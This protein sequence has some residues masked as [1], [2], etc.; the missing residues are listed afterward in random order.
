MSLEELQV[1]LDRYDNKAST[2]D[3]ATLIVDAARRV[4]EASKTLKANLEIWFNRLGID[5][6][7]WWAKEIHAYLVTEYEGYQTTS[8]SDP[9]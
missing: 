1:A 3:D 9:G 8:P 7:E 6:P 2:L 4:T 5:D